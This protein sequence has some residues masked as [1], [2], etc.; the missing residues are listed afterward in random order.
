MIA[1]YS[2]HSHDIGPIDNFL[3]LVLLKLNGKALILSHKYHFST[4]EIMLNFPVTAIDD[5]IDLMDIE[6]LMIIR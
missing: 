3:Y 2:R 6:I 1:G 4:K 5:I